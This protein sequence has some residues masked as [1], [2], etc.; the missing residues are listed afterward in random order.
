MTNE[1]DR[2]YKELKEKEA[3][4]K[5][6]K[7]LKKE[8]HKKAVKKVCLTT[9]ILFLL[10][11][12]LALMLPE[13]P[14]EQIDPPTE[15]KLESEYAEFFETPCLNVSLPDV[16]TG[17][18]PVSG[19]TDYLD[20]A[21]RLR[22]ERW[23]NNVKHMIIGQAKRYDFLSRRKEIYE[24]HLKDCERLI[25]NGVVRNM[26][27]SRREHEKTRSNYLT[28]RSNSRTSTGSLVEKGADIDYR[29]DS[30][31]IIRLSVNAIRYKGYRCK[32]VSSIKLYKYPERIV[33]EC[34]KGRDKYWIQKDSAGLMR[35]VTRI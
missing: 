4:E 29:I 20:I 28:R 27:D 5:E 17:W 13:V 14:E 2:K 8:R 23:R 30:D 32:S 19:R 3:D 26:A 6:K 16:F 31:K 18:P 1:L 33:V 7:R 25:I 22:D 12:V 15:A 21:R 11:I 35:Q 9:L 24:I 34:N 10:L